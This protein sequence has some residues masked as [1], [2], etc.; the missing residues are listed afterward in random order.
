MGTTMTLACSL[1]AVAIVGHIGDSRAYLFRDGR[2]SQLTRDHTVVQGLM[3]RGQLTPAEAPQH[4]WRHALSRSLGAGDNTFEG[5]FQ[6]LDLADGD[7]LLLCTDGL[8]MHVDDAG[9]AAVLARAATADE[10]CRAL[11]QEALAK[12]VRDNITVALARYRF[13][14]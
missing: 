11:V 6:R 8:T 1:G 2:L 7:Q 4:P 5:E 3:D 12:G 9:M 10:V 13:T 14:A